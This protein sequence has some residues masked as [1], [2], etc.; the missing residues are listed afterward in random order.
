M[1]AILQVYTKPTCLPT[2]EVMLAGSDY[3]LI[4]GPTTGLD[5][6]TGDR[7][8]VALYIKNTGDK[9]A[10]DIR[11]VKDNDTADMAE[12]RLE[13]NTAYIKN[14]VSMGDLLPTEVVPLYIRVTVT[15]G[16]PAMMVAPNFTFKFKSLP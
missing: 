9:P 12:F 6:D 11:L 4:L 1:S 8:D 13:G 5:G 16:T 14:D 7:A 15:K 10:I 3:D 2:E